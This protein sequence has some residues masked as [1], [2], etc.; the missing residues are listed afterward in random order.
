[1]IVTRGMYDKEFKFMNKGKEEIILIKPLPTKNIKALY[2]VINKL[3][4]LDKNDL[5]EEEVTQKMIA[6]FADSEVLPSLVEI[7][8]ETI[9]KGYP[10]M[11][12]VTL[13]EFVQAN[14]FQLMPFIV[15][16]NLKKQ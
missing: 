7:V 13:D 10:D 16:V 14:M 11:D 3:S 6:L 8:T 12:P 15:E 5:S 9:R 2:K 4:E 1:M